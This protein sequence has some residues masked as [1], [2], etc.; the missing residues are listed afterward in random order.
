MKTK[1]ELIKELEKYKK[2]SL[3]DP[4]TGLYNRRKLMKDLETYIYR[5]KR[6]K[7]NY[8]LLLLDVDNF[9]SINDNKGHKEG[10][11]I[12]RKIARILKTTIRKGENCYRLSGDEFILIVRASYPS[13]LKERIEIK[14]KKNKINVSIGFSP[15]N[16][17]SLDKADKMMYKEKKI[18]HND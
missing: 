13:T 18:K 2:L 14:M 12:L 8:S 10:D 9:K 15:L 16:L 3:I 4:L 1:K 17:R 7:D 6:Y 11:K 5:Q